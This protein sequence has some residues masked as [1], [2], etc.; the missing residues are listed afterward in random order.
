MKVAVFTLTWNRL[1]YT[2]ACL[3]LL[4]REWRQQEFDH[5]IWDNG[6]TDG[7]EEWLR[8]VA[9]RHKGDVYVHH[10]PTNVGIKAPFRAFLNRVGPDY[11][12]IIKFD[13][14]CEI[15]TPGTLSRVVDAHEAAQGMRRA[16]L[17]SPIVTGLGPD[18]QRIRGDGGTSFELGAQPVSSAGLGGLFQAFSPHI[19]DFR[20]GRLDYAGQDPEINRWWGERE[21][22]RGYLKTCRV[23]HHK[24]T[25]KQVR[26]YPSYFEESN[27]LREKNP[28][29]GSIIW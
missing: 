18:G 14:D 29:V 22:L 24:T 5:F 10:H 25:A 9:L 19:R 13:N 7:T 11:D 2:Q 26:E 4:W 1:K 16:L 21:W 23:A 8:A 15:I 17:I 28:E 27:R 6:S 3:A 20:H 12:V